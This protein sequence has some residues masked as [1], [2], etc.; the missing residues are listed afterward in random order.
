M[1]DISSE[2]SIKLNGRS[3]TVEVAGTINTNEPNKKRVTEAD[4][5]E[6]QYDDFRV[7]KPSPLQN[8]MAFECSKG[9]CLEQFRVGDIVW[10]KSN[11]R[12]DF[13]AWPAKVIDRR[14]MPQ[15]LWRAFGFL[16]DGVLSFSTLKIA[17][18]A[19]IDG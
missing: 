17:G 3:A 1:I 10:V 18:I 14:K 2:R 7:C 16:E 4:Q 11:R 8:S 19:H 13:P 15:N 5:N 9:L 6:Q 12:K